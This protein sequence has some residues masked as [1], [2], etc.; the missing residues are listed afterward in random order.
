[1][2]NP[3]S[4]L[5]EA[6]KNITDESLVVLRVPVAGCYAWEKYGAFWDGLDA[7][8]H[9]FIPTKKSLEILAEKSGFEIINIFCDS[10]SMQFWASEQYKRGIPL[11]DS[12]SYSINTKNSIFNKEQ[13]N[14][15]KKEA[16]KLNLEG[17]GDTV[18]IVLKKV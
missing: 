13:I 8:R 1:M 11:M 15:F 17:D 2:E 14:N 9:L 16:K 18:C 4:I 5:K 10:T 7:P 3:V 12:R 6:A